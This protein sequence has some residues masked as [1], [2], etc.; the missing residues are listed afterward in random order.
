[1]NWLNWFKSEKSINTAMPV[2]GSQK[3]HTISEPYTG[4][5]QKNEELKLSDSL[6]SYAVFSC[7]SLISKDVG[8]LSVILKTEE[9]GILVNSKLENFTILNKPNK[10]QTRQQFFESWINSKATK[11]N[12][13]VF[14]IRDVYGD[15]E[16]LVVLDPDLVAPLVDP[17]GNVF[18]RINTDGLNTLGEQITVP[19]SEIIHDRYNCFYHPLIGLSPIMASGL[20]A[21][22]GLNIQQFSRSFFGN[23]STPSGILVTPNAISAEDAKEIKHN[24]DQRYSAGGAG[25]T[26]I[27]G[28]AMTYQALSVAATDSQM[29]EHLKLSGEIVCST[30]NVPSFKVGVGAIPVGTKIA[31][32]NEIYYSDCLQHYIEAIENL[33]NE[34]LDLPSNVVVEFSIKSLIRMDSLSQMN[35]LK[36]GT[37]SGILTPNEARAELGYQ[38]VE[39]GNSP[40]VQQQNY[41]LQA[42]AKRDAKEDPFT[43]AT[44]ARTS[45]TE[46]IKEV[47]AANAPVEASKSVEDKLETIYKGIF[48]KSVEYSAGSFITHKG[49]LW[50]CDSKHLGDFDYNNFT[51]A[52][53]KGEADNVNTTK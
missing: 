40:M 38:P 41:S 45:P 10:Y 3:W 37:G 2:N 22:T 35:Y 13:Y 17:L 30:F 24:W 21:S 23:N 5:W 52:V 32:L 4:A 9:D 51:L 36:E 16:S 53:K 1:M 33:L 18:Y 31:D 7:I 44:E 11:G 8:K 15:I 6:S 26:A 39:G 12:T 14:K 20:A 28:D 48:N 27:L 34:H 25:G 49:S 47:I 19:S 46:A 42:L 50:H 43:K 29:I